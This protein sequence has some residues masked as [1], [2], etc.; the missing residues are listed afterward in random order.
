MRAVHRPVKVGKVPRRIIGKV[1]AINLK[2]KIISVGLRQ[3]T[4]GHEEDC[5]PAVHVMRN[6]FEY[7]P[8]KA[9]LLVDVDEF[10]FC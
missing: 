4:V 2:D 9:L 1:V 8:S 6:N 10:F 5:E 3:V 7:G